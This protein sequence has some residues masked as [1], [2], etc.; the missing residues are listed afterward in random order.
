MYAHF[1]LFL[2]LS[3]ATVSV[4]YGWPNFSRGHCCMLLTQG[5]TLLFED[6]QHH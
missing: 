5:E 4:I 3:C 2:I 1:F 6:F